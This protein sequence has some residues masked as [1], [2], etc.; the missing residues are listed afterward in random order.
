MVLTVSSK[1]SH[2]K[3]NE[4]QDTVSLLETMLMSEE[5]ETRC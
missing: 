5:S 3:G 2:C 4:G 1:T